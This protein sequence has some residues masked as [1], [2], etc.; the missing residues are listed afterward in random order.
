MKT[1]AKCKTLNQH[2][3]EM[4]NQTLR[5]LLP[6]VAYIVIKVTQLEEL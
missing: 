6:L 1:K 3:A 2:K 5:S 4:G